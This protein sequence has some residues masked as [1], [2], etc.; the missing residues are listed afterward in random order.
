MSD[1]KPFTY[2]INPADF[3]ALHYQISNVVMAGH[4]YLS[5]NRTDADMQT[6]EGVLM[7]MIGNLLRERDGQIAALEASISTPPPAPPHCVGR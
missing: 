1:E 2:G 7:A 4:E 6:H 3:E 5:G